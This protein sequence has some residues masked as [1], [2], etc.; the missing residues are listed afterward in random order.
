MALRGFSFQL[1][2]YVFGLEVSLTASDITLDLNSALHA[3]VA[4]TL[5]AAAPYPQ[6]FNVL[7]TS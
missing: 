5:L 3:Y 6:F 7:H 1:P 2:S 4:C